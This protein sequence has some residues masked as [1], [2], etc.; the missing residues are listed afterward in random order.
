MDSPSDSNQVV[1]PARRFS[2][3]GHALLVAATLIA[4]ALTVRAILPFWWAIQLLAALA[5][6]A[7]PGVVLA[8]RLYG[9]QAGVWSAALLAGPMWGYAVS[10]LVLLA[11]WALGVR[12]FA[13][14]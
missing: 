1:G 4:I 12:S 13:W 11:M 8:R 7:V 9:R 2:L 3:A 5:W 14:L 6:F 10:S